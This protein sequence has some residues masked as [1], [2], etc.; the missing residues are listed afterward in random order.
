MEPEADRT[1]STSALAPDT[2]P[3]DAELRPSESV[4]EAEAP[5]RTKEPEEADRAE[6]E[7]RRVR[8][9]VTG[10]MVVVFLIVGGLGAYWFWSDPSSPNLIWTAIWEVLWPWGLLAVL[11]GGLLQGMRCA[12]R[13]RRES[14]DGP[15][16]T[17]EAFALAAFAMWGVV[18]GFL[19]E[20]K[21]DGQS[22][23][24]VLVVIAAIVLLLLVFAPSAL[25]E[26]KRWLES[27]L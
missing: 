2:T 4:A 13:I 6:S 14:E 19:K 5:D 26:I 24:K 12:L 22:L 9:A 20:T 1:P 25:E 3:P 10:G 21:E 16:E 8:E 23:A 17:G 18:R 11:A 15:V 27:H 7:D